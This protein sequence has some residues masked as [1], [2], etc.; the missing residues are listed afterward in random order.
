[1]E[2]EIN[3]IEKYFLNSRNL[4]E[5]HNNIN[6]LSPEDI[7]EIFKK[8]YIPKA[9][10]RKDLNDEVKYKRQWKYPGICNSEFN[11]FVGLKGEVLGY[12]ESTRVNM[13]LRS[14]ETYPISKQVK[15][16][17]I[18][19]EFGYNDKSEDTSEQYQKYLKS[20]KVK[21]DVLVT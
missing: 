2:S 5:F 19:K 10:T 6:N 21:F 3:K 9:K 17:L 4:S 18:G 20:H 14:Y 13:P 11:E 8:S 15:N 12:W 1:M 7:K 16:N